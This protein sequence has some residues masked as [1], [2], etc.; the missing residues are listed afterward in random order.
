M[1]NKASPSDASSSYQSSVSSIDDDIS[2]IGTEEWINNCRKM[3]KSQLIDQLS[4]ALLNYHI[5]LKS[6][7]KCSKN[8]E[9][10][11]KVSQTIST[12]RIDQQTETLPL[13]IPSKKE[14]ATETIPELVSHEV[15]KH[16][17]YSKS[18]AEAIKTPANRAEQILITREALREENER[19]IRERSIV[20]KNVTN[21]LMEELITNLSQITN[22]DRKSISFTKLSDSQNG[23]FSVR[24]QTLS[25]ETADQVFKTLIRLRS[26]AKNKYGLM[27]VRHFYSKSELIFYRKLWSIAIER[28]NYEQ[29]YLWKVQNLKLIKLSKPMKWETNS[30]S[31][32]NKSD[33]DDNITPPAEFSSKIRSQFMK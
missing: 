31:V 1:S 23:L 11:N 15:K 32:F 4:E 9:T 28:N 12:I 19:H 8:I 17:E 6:Y 21:D 7:L 14:Q 30:K 10:K 24:L 26:Q 33:I 13:F 16:S 27:T 29:A 20:I 3:T 5:T 22:V 2:F 18:Y 25:K